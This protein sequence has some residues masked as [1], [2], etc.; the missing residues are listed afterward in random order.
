MRSTFPV[1]A[2]LVLFCCAGPAEE[3]HDAGSSSLDA[4]DDASP[5]DAAAN[6]DDALADAKEELDFPPDEQWPEY[7]GEPCNVDGALGRCLP[8]ESCDGVAT[9]GHCPGPAGIQCCVTECSSAGEEGACMSKSLCPGA[10]RSSQCAGPSNVGCC[11]SDEQG[12]AYGTVWNTYY[13]LSLEADYDGPDDTT[14]FDADCEPIAEVPAEYSDDVC[15]EGTGVLEDGTVV[16][17]AA[18]CDCGRPCPTGGTVCWKAL[19]PETHPWGEGAFGNAPVPMRS[20]AVDPDAIPLRTV[21]YLPKFDGLEIPAVGGV[22]A[23]THDGCFRADDVG[24]AI[25]GDHID[26][27]AGSTAMWQA[28]EDV[29]PTRTNFALYLDVEQCRHLEL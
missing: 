25:E 2:A 23:F 20:I 22:D 18:T 8:T 19:D 1:I 9:P 28:M 15:I 3:S 16:N 27:F 7:S 4:G 10:E 12:V 13:Y 29:Y 21:V 14:L 11:T 24:G 6:P 26:I 5:T 17:Y